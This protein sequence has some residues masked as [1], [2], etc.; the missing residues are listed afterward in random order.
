MYWKQSV[1]IKTCAKPLDSISNR[2]KGQR[3]LLQRTAFKSQRE[4]RSSEH[5]Q[6]EQ[7]ALK[8]VLRFLLPKRAA[9]LRSGSILLLK[10]KGRF[11]T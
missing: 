9:G 7:E 1:T 4:V 3:P 5:N 10:I 8:D 2:K 11:C 6:N